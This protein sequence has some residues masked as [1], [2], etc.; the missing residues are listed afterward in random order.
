MAA[1]PTS[2]TLS[3]GPGL[4]ASI[5]GLGG[6]GNY[7]NTVFIENAAGTLTASGGGAAIILGQSIG[8]G[9]G[10]GGFA[11]SGNASLGGAATLAVGG[12][13]GAGS[14]AN[15]VSITNY[16]A[17]VSQATAVETTFQT[18]PTTTYVSQTTTTYEPGW[19]CNEVCGPGLVPVTT[20]TQVPVT[21]YS[22]VPTTQTVVSGASIYGNAP[23]ILG[24]SIGGGGGSGGFAVG[25]SV[26]GAGTASLEV[27]GSG[28]NGGTGA[29]VTIAN[30]N[31]I[32]LIGSLSAGIV[33]QSLGGAGGTGGFVVAAGLSSG[34]S[35][36]TTIGGGGGSG[37]TS[38][39]V[40][41]NHGTVPSPPMAISLP[42]SS[43][44]PL[45]GRVAA[46][47]GISPGRWPVPERRA[48]ASAAA[49]AVAVR[50]VG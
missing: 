23:G 26:S 50:A 28:G 8:G 30:Y 21:T 2:L 20:T 33:A 34:A 39:A 25:G 6:S 44:S 29:A 11:A 12:S 32:T 49:A 48:W 3:L 9:G 36:T 16:G 37:G 18:V 45:A 17:I 14:S 47:A 46:A 38:G 41:I 7:S 42:P 4:G 35:A 40:T 19:V 27:G 5:G 13:G 24:Q 22:T 10:N 1:T 43:P 15:T 31:N